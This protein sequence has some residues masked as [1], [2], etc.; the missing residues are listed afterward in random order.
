M[1]SNL[2]KLGAAAAIAGSA[3]YVMKRDKEKKQDS[4]SDLRRSDPHREPKDLLGKEQ[5]F[6]QVAREV[7]KEESKRTA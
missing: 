6:A 2:A 4:S 5:H 3:Y 1:S 7:S